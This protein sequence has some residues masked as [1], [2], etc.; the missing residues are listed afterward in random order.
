[1]CAPGLSAE[2]PKGKR[3]GGRGVEFINF[4]NIFLKSEIS[5][6]LSSCPGQS[7]QLLESKVKSERDI[8][9]EVLELKNVKNR[10]ISFLTRILGR[11]TLICLGYLA[12]PVNLDDAPKVER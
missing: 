11:T 7:G 8:R 6:A 4:P 1:M 12:Y 5:Y 10:E 2:V 3:G 9:E